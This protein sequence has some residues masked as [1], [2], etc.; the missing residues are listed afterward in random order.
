MGPHTPY[1][2]HR[3]FAN[4]MWL[5]NLLIQSL[6]MLKLSSGGW[7]TVLPTSSPERMRER[8]AAFTSLNEKV[9][10]IVGGGRRPLCVHSC[11]S[12]SRRGMMDLSKEV[13]MT[14]GHP[15]MCSPFII[16]RLVGMRFAFGA[17]RCPLPL[18]TLGVAAH[19]TMS[20]LAPNLQQRMDSTVIA[21]LPT[22]S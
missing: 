7:T 19:P 11:R 20:S 12:F 9:D 1:H 18:A 5:L 4:P 16:I 2:S 8:S 14:A 6:L 22:P 13:E 17:P 3:P 21:S 15:M 10:A